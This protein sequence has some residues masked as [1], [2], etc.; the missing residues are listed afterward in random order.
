MKNHA[1]QRYNKSTNSEA[2][3]V[4]QYLTFILRDE[5]YGLDI[6][7][8]REIRGYETVTRIANT[9]EF[10]KGVINLRGNIIPITDLRLKFNMQHATYDELTIVIILDVGDRIVGIVVDGVSDVVQLNSEQI[11]QVP[12]IS[13]EID[14]RYITGLATLDEKMLILINI[15]KLMNSQDMELVDTLSERSV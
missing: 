11:R 1:N 7:T 8:V 10:I 3:Q 9:P 15:E 2:N 4:Q 12:D 5:I 13:A 14:T 6:L